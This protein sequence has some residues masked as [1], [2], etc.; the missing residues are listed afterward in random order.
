MNKI[1]VF[2]AVTGGKDDVQHEQEKDGADFVAFLERG[3]L[4]SPTWKIREACTLFVDPRRNARIHK[5]LAHQYFPEYEYSLWMDGPARLKVPAW[6]LVTKF[7]DADTDLVLFE[8][9]ERRC[10]YEEMRVCAAWKLEDEGV[11][12]EQKQAYEQAGYPVN[13]GLFESGLLLRR[14]SPKMELFNNL[15]WSELSRHSKRDQISLPFAL[16]RAGLK[17]KT[18]DGTIKTKNGRPGNPYFF[19]GDHVK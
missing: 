4:L 2:T 11:I 14:H 9:P 18:F 5:I 19:Y 1:V 8:H 17:V 16:C 10:V 13:A 3:A 12:E 6:L 7:M 15:W